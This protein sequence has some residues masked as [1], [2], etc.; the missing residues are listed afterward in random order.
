VHCGN[1]DDLITGIKK[2][3][4]DFRRMVGS[5]L[6]HHVDCRNL[7]VDFKLFFFGLYTREMSNLDEAIEFSIYQLFHII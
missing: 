3:I 4:G 6:K 1:D 7:L 2:D 5:L